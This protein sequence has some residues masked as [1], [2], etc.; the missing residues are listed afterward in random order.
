M[1]SFCSSALQNFSS[2][3]STHSFSKS[4]NFRSLSFLWLKCHFHNES[5]PFLYSYARKLHT[6]LL[7]WKNKLPSIEVIHK[8]IGIYPPNLHNVIHKLLLTCGKLVYFMFIY[9]QNAYFTSFWIYT[10][11]QV[12]LIL[13]YITSYITHYYFLI[14]DCFCYLIAVVWSW[15]TP[16]VFSR[17]NK[18]LN[19]RK[20]ILISIHT[21]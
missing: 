14:I 8:Y 6:R 3:S 18:I 10:I 9:P 13:L 1:S 17:T 2:V 19:V 5:P 15:S 20:R 12:N 4:M 21:E 7:Y 16:S 11:F